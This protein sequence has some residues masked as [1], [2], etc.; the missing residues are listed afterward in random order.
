MEAKNE[1]SL[2]R[3]ALEFPLHQHRLGWCALTTN[4]PPAGLGPWAFWASAGPKCAKDSNT[5]RGL[6]V[7]KSR[8]LE[9]CRGLEVVAFAAWIGGF[10]RSKSRLFQLLEA[11]AFLPPDVALFILPELV[12]FFAA[13]IGGLSDRSDALRPSGLGVKSRFLV[14]I[15]CGEK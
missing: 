5:G 3:A 11:G 2:T 6:E 10:C 9:M 13:R 8:G 15:S 12:T 4:L 7:T 1:P 14:G